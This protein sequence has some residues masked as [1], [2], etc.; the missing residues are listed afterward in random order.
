M[1]NI[2]H[3]KKINV[4]IAVIMLLTFA[5]CAVISPFSQHAYM[6]TTC[7]KVDALNVMGMAEDSYSAHEAEVATLKTNLQKQY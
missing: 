3:T 1:K 7:L 2:L 4:G 5:H 6:Q